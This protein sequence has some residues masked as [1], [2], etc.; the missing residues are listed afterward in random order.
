MTTTQA[1]STHAV[2]GVA[3]AGTA[4][5]TSHLP[6]WQ[7][8]LIQTVLVLIQ[9]LAAKNNSETDQKGNKLPPPSK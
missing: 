7:Q 8:L 4:M 9:G 5:Q 2:V 1:I 6:W 3:Q